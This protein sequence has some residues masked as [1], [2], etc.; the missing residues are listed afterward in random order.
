MWRE[1]G[2]STYGGEGIDMVGGERDILL[3]LC[4]DG[5]ECFESSCCYLGSTVRC[6][7]GIVK[8]V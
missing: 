5:G 4:N 7:A 1:R 8:V 2:T 6:C 3:D